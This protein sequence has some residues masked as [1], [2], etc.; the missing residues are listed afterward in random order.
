MI[1][2]CIHEVDYING[3]TLN[4]TIKLVFQL[5]E[6]GTEHLAICIPLLNT[7]FD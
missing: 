6:E 1:T 2:S 4:F 3:L 7:K 5:L